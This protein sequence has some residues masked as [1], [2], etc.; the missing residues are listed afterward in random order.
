MF[1]FYFDNLLI[2]LKTKYPDEDTKFVFI[3]DNL[4]SHKSS[5]VIKIMS[6]KK[7][8][9]LYTPSNTPQFSPIENMF[10]LTKKKM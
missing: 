9:V 1:A 7:V 6:D 8:H 2:K 3:L 5:L 10:G 4:S